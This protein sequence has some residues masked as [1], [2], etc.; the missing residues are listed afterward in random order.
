MNTKIHCYRCGEL[1]TKTFIE[2]DHKTRLF[3]PG[4]KKPVYENPVP[5]TAAVVFNENEEILLVQ[6]KVE[7]HIGEWCLPGGYMELRETPEQCCM[8]ELKEET[9]LEGEIVCQLGNILSRNMFYDSIIVQGYLVKNPKGT[10]HASDDCLDAKF[11]ALNKMPRITFESHQ[12]IFDNAIRLKKNYR[13]YQENRENFSLQTGNWGAYVI[14][15][16]D[17][18]EIAAEACKGGAKI[19]QYREKRISRKE[20]LGIALKIREITRQTNTIFIVNDFI[21]IALLSGADGVHLGQ[22]DIP[23]SKARELTPKGFIIG[24]STHSL[25]QA[26]EAEKQGADYIGSGPVFATPTKENYIPIGMSTLKEVLN[27]V[28]IPVVAIGGIDT[29]NIRE[30]YDLGARNFA[31]VRAFQHNTRL[32]VEKVNKLPVS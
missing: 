3:C 18:V 10:L 8:R 29:D 24:V 17:P 12:E 20:M 6:R 11:F 26:L 31:M 13:D 22:D 27:A 16:Q 9:G 5:S 1:L 2:E 21:D 14:T 23:I 15:S 32:V 19:L 7:P 30:L 28:Q 25:E 4:C